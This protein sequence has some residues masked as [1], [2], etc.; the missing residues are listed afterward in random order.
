MIAAALG[1]FVFGFIVAAGCFAAVA[2]LAYFGV[3]DDA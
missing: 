1:A 3:D 2:F